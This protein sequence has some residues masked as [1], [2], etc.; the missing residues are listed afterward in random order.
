M[1]AGSHPFVAVA[2]LAAEAERS[3]LTLVS[4]NN[5]S[6]VRLVCDNPTVFFKLRADPRDSKDRTDF[7]GHKRI[8]LEEDDMA[9]GPAATLQ[10]IISYL[11]HYSDIPAFAPRP[12]S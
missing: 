7:G 6:Y 9:N 1:G 4:E 8:V 12:K 3:D 2:Q 10:T 5:G 11:K